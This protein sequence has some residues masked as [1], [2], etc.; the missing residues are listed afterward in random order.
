[1]LLTLLPQDEEKEESEGSQDGLSAKF[2]ASFG[3]KDVPQTSLHLGRR[4]VMLWAG[5]YQK[6]FESELNYVESSILK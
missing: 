2:L 1:M 3:D 6:K 4:N 5:Y